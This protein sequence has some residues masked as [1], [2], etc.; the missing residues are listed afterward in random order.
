MGQQKEKLVLI[1]NG[2]AGI[3]TIEEVLDHSPDTFEITIF[4]SEPHA[5]YNRLQLSSVLQG[6]QSFAGIELNNAD[7]Y[8]E[9]RIDLRTG[10][11][12]EQID[13]EAKTI[14]TDSQ[15][16]FSYDKLIIATGSNPIF[17]PLPGA[18][19]EGVMAF[20]TIN[21]CKKMMETAGRYKKAAVIGGGL[22]GLE[23]ARG[24]LNLGMEVDVVHLAGRLMERQ[25]DPTAAGLLK[26]ELEAQ[27]MNFFLEKDTSEL[28]GNERV[29][30]LRFQ[31]GTQISADLVVMAVGVK[32]NIE[33][34][35]C[36]GIHTNKGI[37]VDDHLRTNIP[38]IY[39]V[40]ECAEHR[41]VV[42]A[43]VKPIYKQAKV[44]GK[45]ISGIGGSV[46]RGTV[47]SMQLKVSGVDVF[48]AGEFIPGEGQKSLTVFDELNDHYKKFV[49]HGDQLAGAILFGDT[50]DGMHALG[51]IVEDKDLSEEEKQALIHAVHPSYDRIAEMP[52][53][54]LVCNCNAVSKGMIIETVQ[55]SG[56]TSVEGIKKETNA[57]G[58]C[59]SCKSAVAE[60]LD[61]IHSDRFDEAIEV[62]SL[63]SCTDYTEEQIVE[64]IQVRELQTVQEVV[65]TL[66]WPIQEGC[67][68]CRDALPYYLG[69]IHPHLHLMEDK[70]AELQ[71]DGTYTITPP[72][73]GGFV[74]PE[75]LARVSALIKQFHLPD[76][77]ITSDQRLQLMGV[78]EGQLDTVWEQLGMPERSIK[79]FSVQP[80]E[81][82]S[83]A[84]DP[85]ETR[86]LAF[87][88]DKQLE[89][90]QFPATVKI[91][92]KACAHDPKTTDLLI[93]RTTL[94]WEIHIGSND[95]LYV[96]EETEDAFELVLALLQYYRQ[97][98]SYR[99]TLPRWVTK[100][101]II[102]VREIVLD[103]DFR[104]RLIKQLKTDASINENKTA[105]VKLDI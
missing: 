3:R 19:K 39:A 88:L 49:F 73:Y 12:V 33:L 84:C 22:L 97:A 68:I 29:E 24:L 41:D 105:I 63:C 67:Y 90:L 80:V 74:S 18:D 98:A 42:Y 99:E 48:S 9:N 38:D 76:V 57:S 53:T 26:E 35:Q 20:R 83:C 25:L 71:N 81:T 15:L 16:E 100:V 30:G 37:I 23:A 46:Y 85:T 64:E 21:D 36:S 50:R 59:G 4:G 87:H 13:S 82:P 60:M 31:D 70:N 79:G 75:Q 93:G 2:M 34:A 55:A 72:L 17:I 10:E 45:E 8:D 1:G 92:T 89:F 96:A 77:T 47:L 44:L 5:S 52:Q 91:E 102:H 78:K 14:T 54:E 7:W 66:D 40:G 28:F 103:N 95:L 27:G 61:Y 6:G 62:A 11:T 94:G 69:M 104:N 58:S 32:P 51:Q 43:L 56:A 65:S 86:A 101:G